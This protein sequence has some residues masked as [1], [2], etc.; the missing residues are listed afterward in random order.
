[1]S[2]HVKINSEEVLDSTRLAGTRPLGAWAFHRRF[3]LWV[4]FSQRVQVSMYHILGHQGT[5]NI[6]STLRPKY[7]CITYLGTNVTPI[8]KALCGQS[9][10]WRRTWTLWGMQV[11]VMVL[12]SGFATE[13]HWKVLAVARVLRTSQV[14]YA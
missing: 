6:E 10:A 1:M 2:E 3:C 7:P 5:R 12:A 13:L 8:W 9:I 14:A 11:L 4:S